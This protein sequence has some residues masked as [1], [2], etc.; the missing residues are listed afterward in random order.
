MT[1]HRRHQCVPAA[2]AVL[3]ATALLLSAFLPLAAQEPGSQTGLHY[4]ALENLT[5]GEIDQRGIAGSQGVAFDNLILAPNTSYR[6][7]IIQAATLRIGHVEFRTGPPGQDVTIPEIRL[8]PSRIVDADDD[9]LP[10]LAEAILGTDPFISD[11]DGDGVSDG[12]EVIQG[13]DPLDGLAVRTGI[14]ASVDVTGSSVDLCAVDDL[15][16]VA[17]GVGVIGFNIFTGMNPQVVLNVTTPG[18]STAVACSSALRDGGR[19]HLAV[20]CG[21][22]GLVVIDATEPQTATVVHQVRPVT[23]G[24]TPRAVAAAAGIAYVGLSTGTVAAVDLTSGFIFDRARVDAGIDALRIS[25]GILYATWGRS[26]HSIRLDPTSLEVL[27]GASAPV[28]VA[29]SNLAAGSGLTFAA[30]AGGVLAFSVADPAAPSLLGSVVAD[31]TR[32]R[33]IAVNG[34]GFL[35]GSVEPDLSPIGNLF[36]Y[37][38]SDPETPAFITEIATPGSAR[39]IEIA[40]GLAYVAD[41][42]SGLQVVNYL[43]FD[44]A[45]VP[46]EISLTSSFDV[47]GVEEGKSVFVTASVSDDVQVRSV[48]FVVDGEVA[49]DPSFPFEHY[50]VTPRRAAQSS[51]RLRA[52]AFDTGGN[53][54]LTDEIIVPLTP[55]VTPPVVVRQ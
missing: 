14:I 13:I 34:S 25:A 28:N 54:T 22:A 33:D 18:E 47:A 53:E 40:N 46:P 12:A 24:G 30:H 20:V 23:L 21:D 10:D 48:E 43:A 1:S 4:Y 8:G 26:L 32:W 38:V 6:A 36:L 42:A 16:V 5:R 50:F 7:W 17:N 3:L 29:F 35:V 55:D 27:G 11:S 44:T 31:R 49:T 37:D 45:G 19:R 39:G 41:E 15:L 2:P 51:F 9:G 52:R